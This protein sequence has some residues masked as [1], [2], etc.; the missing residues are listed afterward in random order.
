MSDTIKQYQDYMITSM[1]KQ[2]EPVVVERG[3]GARLFD[4][5]GREYID[6]FS[7]IS[8]VNTGH[9]NQAVAAAAKAQIDKMVHCASYVYHSPPTAALAEQ[10]AAIMPGGGRLRKTFFANS[11]AESVEGALR[12]AKAYTGKTEIIALQASF[13][14]R[15]WGGLSITG[16]SK[17]K[18]AGGP[19]ASGIAFAPA[20]YTYRSLF[21][22][23]TET[24]AARSAQALEEVIN[25][26]TSGD[27][28]AFIAEPIMGEGGIIVPP[29]SYFTRVKEILDRHKI[30]FICDEVQTGFCRTGKMFA[31]EHYG[32]EPDIL[33]T[34]KGIANGFPLGGFTTRPE[35][36]EAFR[37]GDHLSTFGGNPVSCA[38][39]LANIAYLQGQELAR[40]ATEKGEYLMGKL[41]DF[42]SGH[43]LI[44]EVRGKGLMVGV[45]LIKD[46]ARDPASAAAD[47]I[48][49]F[50]RKHGLLIGVGGIY[51]N[52]VRW[53]PPL[54]ITRPQLDAALAI[55]ESALSQR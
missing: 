34:A 15:T 9:G 28:A 27:V 55:F 18:R 6:C 23:D 16:N 32:V 26:S 20:P 5:E 8:V 41:T 36:A 31:I 52:V 25:F 46:V 22:A 4:V 13:H 43:S 50:C 1:V 2:V 35:I 12:M 21:G 47:R 11:G 42:K 40:Q 17:R 53:Q 14:G 10:L 19:Y 7:G 51:G 3:E 37:P 33:V 48:R 44:G 30:L 38:A 54:V 29:S 49:E 45:E 24:C 39:A